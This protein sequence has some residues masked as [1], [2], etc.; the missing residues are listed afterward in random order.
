[1]LLTL[2][3]RSKARL[4]IQWDG[5]LP[6][7]LRIVPQNQ[8]KVQLY[9]TELHDTN[10]TQLELEQMNFSGLGNLTEIDIIAIAKWQRGQPEIES[11]SLSIQ[12]CHH[13]G[14]SHWG[15]SREDGYCRHCGRRIKDQSYSY[16]FPKLELSK[17]SITLWNG[18]DGQL[19]KNKESR[20]IGNGIYSM[21]RYQDKEHDR[22]FVEILEEKYDPELS[23]RFVLLHQL[24][25]ELDLLDKE[26]KPPLAAF[27]EEHHRS[28]WIYYPWLP[29]EKKWRNIS[30]WAYIFDKDVDRIG[31]ADIVKIGIQLCKIVEKV[32]HRGYL[33][34]SL[35]LSD[36]MLSK[37]RAD[38]I[39]IYL[40]TRD[41]SWNK[42]E[43]ALLDTCLIPWELFWEEELS[44]GYEITEVYVIAALLYFLRAKSPNLLSYNSLSYPYGLPTLKL[45]FEADDAG[46]PDPLFGYFESVINQALLLHPAE[47]IYRTV[48]EL[49]LALQQLLDTCKI[50]QND[51]TYR[52]EVGECLDVGDEKRESDMSKNQDAVFLTSFLLERDSWG[53]FALCDGVSTATVGSGDRASRTI[54]ETLQSRWSSYSYQQ[55]REI[56]KSAGSDFARACAYL[57][58]IADEANC[59]IRRQAEELAPP[60]KLEE[61]LVMGSTITIGIV[62]HRTIAFGWLGDS[63]IYR[64]SPVF[65]WERL[66]FDHNERN[67]RL[68]E[69]MPLEDCFIEGGNALTH[70]V[71]AHFYLENHLPMNFG[72]AF[73]HPGEHILICS[74]GIPDYIEQEASYARNESYQMLRI[75]SLIYAYEKDTLID[76]RAMASI[77]V[78]GVNR[79]GGGMDNLSA[80]LIRVL[81]ENCVFREKAYHR[82]KLLAK[83]MQAVM[84]QPN[85]QTRR[86]QMPRDHSYFQESKNDLLGNNSEAT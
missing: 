85:L 32:H 4:E 29:R 70:C 1:M 52:L 36:L 23:R 15:L 33:W 38:E 18:T 21:G 77:L 81:P 6:V 42:P 72:R 14:C 17:S 78:S 35:K 66:N 39:S 64:I 44:S 26:W 20:D 5:P 7:D 55:Q 50:S 53:M 37:N 83:S 69:G 3:G 11:E 56:C 49:H 16:G 43:K 62:Y 76:A 25:R 34:A 65:G 10:R 75:A 54:I 9:E 86:V 19:W 68:K 48:E 31:T 13:I 46:Q 51:E 22:D 12:K 57:N 47:R 27:Q 45:F 73:L 40:R 58:E 74:D 30:A 24:L 67:Y 61:A 71:G 41:L 82:L 84:R 8:R 63:P 60:E 2:R 59:L 79:I 28:L 80:I